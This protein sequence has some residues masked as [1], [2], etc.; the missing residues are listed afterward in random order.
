MVFSLKNVT[1]LALFTRLLSLLA[2]PA[3]P[4]LVISINFVKG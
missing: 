3:V 2:R 4:S 1:V